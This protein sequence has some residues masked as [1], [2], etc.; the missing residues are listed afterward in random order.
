MRRC[1]NVRNPASESM[2]RHFWKQG[3][4]L[5]KSGRLRFVWNTVN[6]Q[7]FRRKRRGKSRNGA[8]TELNFEN[9]MHL[10]NAVFRK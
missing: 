6:I 1:F 5:S 4:D 8:S 7:R 9:G 2:I 10:S 3:V